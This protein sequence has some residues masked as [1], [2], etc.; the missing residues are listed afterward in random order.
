MS[1]SQAR[2]KAVR[3]LPN[4]RHRCVP[5]CL[6]TVLIPLGT[7]VKTPRKAAQPHTFLLTSLALLLMSGTAV[8][9]ANSV[10]FQEDYLLLDVPVSHS[11]KRFCPFFSQMTVRL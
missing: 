3:L 4:P 6:L 7:Q 10:A 5:D 1:A 11:G 9:H 2:L 8:A